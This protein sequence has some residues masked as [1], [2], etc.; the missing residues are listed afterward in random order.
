VNSPSS[1]AITP[2]RVADL[3]AEG[4]RMP[5]Y[6][7]AID[8]PD[9]RVLIDTGM[10]ELH[11]AVADPDPRLHPTTRVAKVAA[12]KEVPLADLAA[13]RRIRNDS[14]SQV[15]ASL[16][17]AHGLDPTASMISSATLTRG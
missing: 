11:P 16:P 8:H 17:T 1:I 14:W 6:V 4:E 13:K 2:V 9:A 3:L 12:V 5:V 15:E 10:T 7:H